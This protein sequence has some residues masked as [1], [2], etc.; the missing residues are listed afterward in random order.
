MYKLND[1]LSIYVTR[2]DIVFLSV[3]ATNNGEV[4]TF[5]PGDVLRFKVFGK[6]DCEAVALQKDFPV[7]DHCQVVNLFLDEKDTKIGGVISKPV[8]Y[9]YE[10][11]LNPYDDPQTII[12][13]DEDGPKVFKLFPEG[14]DIDAYVPDPE[15]FPVVDEELD[16]TSPRPVS[17]QTIARA[18]ANLQAGYQATH[19]AVANRFV[20]PKMFGAIGDG[21]ADDTKALQMALDYGRSV[22]LGS[23]T[24]RITETL[25]V[26]F[27]SKIIGDRNAVIMPE[28]EVA[29]HLMEKTTLSGFSVSVKSENVLTV[30]EVDDD[31]TS[32]DSMLEIVIEN[33]NV[34][35]STEVMP[36]M[37]TVCHFHASEKGL[38]NVT[39]R[40]CTFDS[41]PA[42][43]YVA[44][45]YAE[46]DGWFSTVIFDGNY[47]RAFKWHYFFDKAENEL[48]NTHK[49][50]HIVSN[51]VAQ[52]NKITN[53]FV[54]MSG[55]NVV[56]VRNNVTWD[57]GSSVAGSVNCPGRPYVIS[58][59]ILNENA[60]FMRPADLNDFGYTGDLSVYDGTSFSNLPYNRQ[61]VLSTLGGRYNSSLIPK[62]IG[63]SKD[64]AILLYDGTS[65]NDNANGRIR[66]YWVDGNG[67]TYVSVVPSVGKVYVSQP[68]S[69]TI[70][71][72][73]SKDNK[74]LYVY[75]DAGTNLPSYTGIITLPTNISQTM[76]INQGGSGLVERTPN[77][78]DFID[79]CYYSE[80]P[81][82]VTKLTMALAQPAYVSDDNGGIY[83]LSVVDGELTI[84]RTYAPQS[85]L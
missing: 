18:F 5:Q 8:D 58:S 38:Y 70:Y 2:G 41:Y 63:L 37:Y 40:G 48:V 49:G 22:M 26:P 29:F 35:H 45:V 33:V 11:E 6:K 7:T 46:G 27:G 83:K 36:D 15:D 3:S 12:G 42:G 55:L 79:R 52:C 78:C 34:T 50:Q 20:S 10:V 72:G 43:G 54:F 75:R 9:W 17:N 28:S 23:C 69:S 47:S 14:A 73:M 16:M 53:G 61:D 57:W 65:Q 81:E 31:S 64:N 30:F 56:S 1:D 80:L 19:E 66:F 59:A 62:F 84:K 4:Y 77:C 39:V 60:A 71:F 25:T 51:C 44:R 76:A 24:Y 74:R 68:I 82:E 21:V 67:I 13:Y 85:E 32:K